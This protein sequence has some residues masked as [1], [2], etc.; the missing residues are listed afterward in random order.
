MIEVAVFSRVW[1]KFVKLSINSLMLAA[2]SMS[3]GAEKWGIKAII[4]F[5]PSRIHERLHSKK[6]SSREYFAYFLSN[7]ASPGSDSSSDSRIVSSWGGGSWFCWLQ[8][9][10]PLP[11]TLPLEDPG[12]RLEEGLPGGWCSGRVDVYIVVATSGSDCSIV[13]TLTVYCTMCDEL[14]LNEYWYQSVLI[15]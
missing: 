7:K 4:F 10:A 2:I 3:N 15:C 11:T 5:S 6:F 12:F 13:S 14:V 9:L 8:L 1:Q